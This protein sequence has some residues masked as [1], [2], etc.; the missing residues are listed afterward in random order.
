M[1]KEKEVDINV[2]IL[3]DK[4]VG[5]TSI[6]N[7]LKE[8]E[9]N[10]NN[11][12][13]DIDCINIK[14]KYE[15]KN[16]IISLNINDVKNINNYK[17]NI[18]SNIIL[19]VFCN[20]KTLNSIKEKWYKYCNE[21]LNNAKYILIGNKYDENNNEEK[22]MIE[23]GQKFGEEIDA[24]FITYS[25]QSKDNMDNVERF[26]IT[27]AKELID[28]IDK[29]SNNNIHHIILENNGNLNIEN[30]ILIYFIKNLLF[31]FLIIEFI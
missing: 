25:T 28:N 23:E 1:E 5:K 21:K 10:E 20:I 8:G 7:I 2:I 26:I 3:G 12:I 29:Q 30:H 4:G 16:I 22:E 31:I 19:L 14:R 6:F 24:H 9:S 15:K 13:N 11:N 27:E 17:G 18:H